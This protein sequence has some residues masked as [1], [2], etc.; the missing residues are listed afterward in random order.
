MREG[1]EKKYGIEIKFFDD[2][3]RK[4]KIQNIHSYVHAASRWCL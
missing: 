1:G 2:G 3:E 4:R